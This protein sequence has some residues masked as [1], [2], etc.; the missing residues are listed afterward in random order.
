MECL[1]ATLPAHDFARDRTPY[2]DAMPTPKPDMAATGGELIA[3]GEPAPPFEL[4]DQEGIVHRLSD[5]QGNRVVVFFYPK[6]DTP[7]C[8]KEACG[9]QEAEALL[10]SAGVIVLGVSPQDQKSK[11][12]FAEK[13]GLTFPVLADNGASVSSAYGVWQ[14]KSMYGKKYAG[15]VRTTYLIDASGR[16]SKRWDKVKVGGH[17]EEVLKEL[18]A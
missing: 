6:D 15:V 16:V 5:H 9:F 8:T 14:E 4:V 11:K 18:E 2:F 17:V 3:E 12:R 13:H 1:L 7:G 10:A